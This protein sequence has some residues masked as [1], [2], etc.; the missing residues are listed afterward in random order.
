MF[1]GP[2]ALICPCGRCA[3]F[4]QI[5]KVVSIRRLNQYVL[6]STCGLPWVQIAPS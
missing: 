6:S 3:A 1:A 5:G 4:P 2:S